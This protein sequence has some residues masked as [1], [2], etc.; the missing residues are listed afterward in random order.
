MSEINLDESMYETLDELEK[1]GLELD[2]EPDE[3]D[4]ETPEVTP[5]ETPEVEEETPE[6]DTETPPEVEAPEPE[7]EAETIEPR[8][9]LAPT[10]WT[11]EAKANY[12]D[13]PAWAKKEVHKREEDVLK[14]ISN[15]KEQSRFG[16]QMQRAVEPYR[17][18]LNQLNV[19]AESAVQ[20]MLNTLYTLETAAPQKKAQLFKDLAQ[21]YQVDLGQV[22]A[23]TDPDQAKFSQFVAPLTQQITQLQQ[24]IQ[25]QQSSTQEQ[26]LREAQSAIESFASSVDENGQPKYPYFENVSELMTSFLQTGRA[27]TLEEAYETAVWADPQTRSLLQSEQTQKAEAERARLA[28]EKA[29]KAR[30]ANKLN[31]EK[32]GSHEPSANKPTGSIDDTLNET[33]ERLS[34]AQN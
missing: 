21:R 11:A 15:L 22:V 32:R 20:G 18:M 31:L 25:R 4:K 10:T 5:D 16:E 2:D 33:F 23:P 24:T 9:N 17:A 19:P 28:K 3:I 1:E 29:D 6:V 14:G 34:A 7:P 13:L 8:L 30:K 26:Q 12:K 27:T